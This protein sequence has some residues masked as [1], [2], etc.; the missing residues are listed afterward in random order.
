MTTINESPMSTRPE[1]YV[2]PS[3]GV[4]VQRGRAM[5]GLVN[6]SQVKVMEQIAVTVHMSWPLWWDF[7]RWLGLGLIRA[8]VWIMGCR[9]GLEPT[10]AESEG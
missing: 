4:Y 7:R 10:G 6:V 5:K 9:F 1:W 8:G 3:C 2:C